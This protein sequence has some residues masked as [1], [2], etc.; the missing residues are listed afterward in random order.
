[1]LRE[2]RVLMILLAIQCSGAKASYEGT[3]RVHLM[4]HRETGV[5]GGRAR[6]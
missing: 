2:R 3:A 5:D 6:E 1:M 4:V